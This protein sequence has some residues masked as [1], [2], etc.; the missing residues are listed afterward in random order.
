MYPA[1]DTI[2]SNVSHAGYIKLD[3]INVQEK[4]MIRFQNVTEAGSMMWCDVFE[5]HLPAILGNLSLVLC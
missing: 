4:H 5:A 2:S 3:V 1:R